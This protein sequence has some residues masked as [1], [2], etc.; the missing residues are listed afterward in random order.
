MYP[1]IFIVEVGVWGFTVTSWFLNSPWGVSTS[2]IHVLIFSVIAAYFSAYWYTL[3]IG[4]LSYFR[5][6]EGKIFIPP[7]SGSTVIEPAN[8]V[9]FFFSQHARQSPFYSRRHA[10]LEL[11]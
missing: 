5:H 3:L 6:K 7:W 2:T 11:R 1:I 4:M 10:C 8:F 9:Q